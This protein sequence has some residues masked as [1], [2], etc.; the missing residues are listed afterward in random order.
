MMK[1]FLLN[2]L[3]YSRSTFDGT[4]TSVNGDHTTSVP[5]AYFL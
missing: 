2:G 1:W 3:N 5:N 4:V